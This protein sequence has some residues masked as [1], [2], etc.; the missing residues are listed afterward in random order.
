LLALAYPFAVTYRAHSNPL[1]DAFMWR[2]RQRNCTGVFDRR[3]IRGA[4]RHLKQGKTLWYAPDQDYGP[5]QA[6]FAP[7]FNRTAAT[8]TAT[9]RFAAIN[10]SVVL[11]L[12]QQRLTDKQKY[13]IEFLPVPPPFPS[14]D[15][16]ADATCINQQLEACI[17]LEPSQYLWMHKRFKTQP[18]GKPQSPYILIKTKRRQLNA[19][20]YQKLT[21]AAVALAQPHRWQLSNGLQLWHYPGT[22][23]GW[24]GRAHS[25]IKLDAI[26]KLLRSHAVVTVTVDSLFLL[27][28]RQETA[29]SCH[30]PRGEPLDTAAPPPLTPARA[31]RFLARVHD[32]GLHFTDMDADNLLYY[33]NRL[34]LLDPLCLRRPRRISNPQR[35]ADLTR[36]LE[37]LSYSPA[38]QAECLQDYLHSSHTVDVPSLH[39]LSVNTG[40]VISASEHKSA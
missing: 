15:L 35:L 25:A 11:I 28:F 36:L 7:F 6:V 32:A 20:L 24:S 39:A 16:V 17:R 5:E 31:A 22:A 23:K 30:I 34:A 13:V 29:V 2:G 10:N 37:L 12:R 9:T 33:N 19:A 1:F 3:D 21:T 40:A 14:G 27:P 18:Y 8:I 4:F 38:Q 26:S